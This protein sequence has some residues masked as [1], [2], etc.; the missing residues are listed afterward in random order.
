MPDRRLKRFYEFDAF[1][2]DV[3]ER[4]LMRSNEHVPL[5]PK[6]FDVLL[7][8]V[9][10][11]GRTLGK[12]ELMNRVW[13]E[14]FVED[15]NLNRNISTLRKVLGEDSR[16][17][18]FIKTVP[19][20]GYRF[21]GDVREIVEEDEE[22]VIE[23]RTNYRLEVERTSEQ[24]VSTKFGGRFIVLTASVIL[25]GVLTGAWLL[26]RPPTNGAA[27][28]AVDR[29][30]ADAEALDLY[31]AGRELWKDRSVEGL[32]EATLKLEQAV[33]K[34]PDFAL[35]HAALADAYAFDGIL[36]KKAEA[37]ANEAVRLDPSLGQPYATLGFIRTFWEWKP[38]EAEAYFK[39]ALALSPDSGTAHQWYS[40]NLAIRKRNGASLAEMQRALELEPTSLAINADLC[41]VLYFSHKFD[42]AMGQCLKTL[43]MD[44]NFISA[45]AYLYDIYTAKG[46]YAEAVGEH[47]KTEELS[48]TSPT[49][50]NDLDDLRSAYAAG[51]IHAFWQTRARQLE[52]RNPPDAYSIAKYKV[53]LGQPDEA[54]AWLERAVQTR[55]FEAIYFVP[56]PS[57]RE[58]G[59]NPRFSDLSDAVLN[60][61][62]RPSL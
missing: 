20:R 14:A 35:A 11:S 61:N 26:I 8:L 53:C 31:K 6:V 4:R 9:E 42:E 15:G 16:N 43:E 62:S 13:A 12:D 36:W 41:Q 32:H 45:H 44:P 23:K 30:R 54:I 29:D 48:R 50:P 38:V 60:G 7:A 39:Q 27:S 57:F 40:I 21:E 2:L 37:R 34:D 52:K 10:S 25:A 47:F 1:R 28:A 5:T 22:I 3:D 49:Y 51:G 24:T 55:Q 18:G 59:N 17:P 33:Q 46:M 56:E 58:L 19:K